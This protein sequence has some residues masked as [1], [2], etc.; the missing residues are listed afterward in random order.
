VDDTHKVMADHSR[1]VVR[2]LQNSVIITLSFSFWASSDLHVLLNEDN[3]GQCWKQAEHTFL[4]DTASAKVMQQFFE[5]WFNCTVLHNMTVTSMTV[6]QA[7]VH[8]DMPPLHDA[9]LIIEDT[10]LATPH[11]SARI[12]HPDRYENCN[13][14]IRTCDL[15]HAAYCQVMLTTWPSLCHCAQVLL[16]IWTYYN[17]LE[18]LGSG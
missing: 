2:R 5:K 17:V 18:Y 13:Y 15:L 10:A 9:A 3:K 16:F 4:S 12:P 7:T 6:K 1:H 14:K 8:A 11:H